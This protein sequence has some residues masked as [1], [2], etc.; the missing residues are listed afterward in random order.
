MRQIAFSQTPVS[1]NFWGSA[2][3]LDPYGRGTAS[4]HTHSLWFHI[5]LLQWDKLIHVLDIQTSTSILTDQEL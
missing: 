3:R 1:K 4:T 5:Y 2:Y